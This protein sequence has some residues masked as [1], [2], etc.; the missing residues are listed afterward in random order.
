MARDSFLPFIFSLFEWEWLSLLPY[1]CPTTVFSEQRACCLGS[2][3]DRKILTHTNLDDLDVRFGT[4]ELI[5]EIL[6]LML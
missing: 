3:V 2:Q 1:V 6:E 5:D 4:S